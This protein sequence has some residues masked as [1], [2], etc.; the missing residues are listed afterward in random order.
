[1]EMKKKLVFPAEKDKKSVYSFL[2][3]HTIG[4]IIYQKMKILLIIFIGI[5]Y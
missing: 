3:V 4:I 1:M 5:H 2:G